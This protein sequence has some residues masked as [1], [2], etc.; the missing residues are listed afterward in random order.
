MASPLESE[1]NISW[2]SLLAATS[3]LIHETYQSELTSKECA[4]NPSEKSFPINAINELGIESKVMEEKIE[5]TQNIVKQ[6][7]S[8]SLRYI[9]GI[10]TVR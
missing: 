6:K 5:S 10:P 4:G 7:S 3:Q 8:K 2:M 9:R 1:N